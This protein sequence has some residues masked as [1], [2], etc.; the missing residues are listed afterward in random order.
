MLFYLCGCSVDRSIVG[1]YA[2]NGNPYKFEFKKDSTF[3]FEYGAI[4]FFEFSL[5]KWK[6]N[7][8]NKFIITSEI[9][10][11]TLPLQLSKVA[12]KSSNSRLNIKLKLTGKLSLQDY[13][14]R[15]FFNNQIVKIIRCD[16]LKDITPPAD[17][18]SMKIQFLRQ[19]IG[20]FYT[21]LRTNPLTTS[22]VIIKPEIGVDFLAKISVP[23]SFFYHRSF[24][25]QRIILKKDYIIFKDTISKKSFRLLKVAND[26]NVF[27]RFR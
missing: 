9:K 12:N 2:T 24:D 16:S 19:P 4:E 3:R 5:G 25:S 23:D 18:K 26:K 11:T 8:K 15:I 27:S 6:R 13:I 7:G 20:D 21:S 22:T 1:K 14:C 17:T 10:N